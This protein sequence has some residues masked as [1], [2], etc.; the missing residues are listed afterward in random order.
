MKQPAPAFH[1]GDERLGTLQTATLRFHLFGLQRLHDR[2]LSIGVSPRSIW[3]EQ[4]TAVAEE[5]QYV[6]ADWVGLIVGTFD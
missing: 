5:C 2:G 3:P 1:A 4:T 6:T